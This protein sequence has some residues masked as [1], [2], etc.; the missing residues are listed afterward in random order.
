[1]SKWQIDRWVDKC[2]L[3]PIKAF[4]PTA[5]QK[6]L[7]I[8]ITTIFKR[9]LMLV[10]DGKLEISWRIICPNCFRQIVIIKNKNIIPRYV[11]CYECGE[12]EVT[13]EMIYPLFSVKNEYKND[14]R[15]Q[16]KTS[17]WNQPLVFARRR[18]TLEINH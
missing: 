4:S 3:K 7:G 10:E 12:Q 18:R 15:S 8:D 14:L 5:V 16:K 9:L 11:E 17:N 13:P 1:M 2:A 6:D